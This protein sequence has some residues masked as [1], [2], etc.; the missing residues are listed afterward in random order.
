V[1]AGIPRLAPSS[2]EAPGGSGYVYSRQHHILLG[3]PVCALPRRFPDP[4]TLPD[5][6]PGYAVAQRVHDA[7]TVLVG[8]DLGEGSRLTGRRSPA[9]LPVRRVH[10]GDVHTDTNLTDCCRRDRSLDKSQNVGTARLRV[11][12]GSH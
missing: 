8:N 7:C 4:D 12:D 10:G 3:G 2:I 1:S 11:H 5:L 6:E 9:G